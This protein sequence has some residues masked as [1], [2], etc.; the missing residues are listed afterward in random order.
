MNHIGLAGLS[1]LHYAALHNHS[2]TVELILL[3]FGSDCN[4]L[5]QAD[6]RGIGEEQRTPLPTP[7]S[8]PLMIA[9]EN[10]F[11]DVARA[12]V[13]G[14]CST[15]KASPGMKVSPLVTAFL[16]AHFDVVKLLIESGANP[17]ETYID[18]VTVSISIVNSLPISIHLL[19]F[20]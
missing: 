15:T 4:L 16:A 1:A 10:G 6:R 8:S 5:T 19:S 20:F 11:I 17:N 9:A 13:H 14:G 18:T 12:L 2:K 3:L 7:G